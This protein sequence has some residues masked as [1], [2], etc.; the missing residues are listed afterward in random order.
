MSAP[1]LPDGRNPLMAQTL[2]IHP[3]GKLYS[4]PWIES[5]RAGA[6][7]KAPCQCDLI[8]FETPGGSR[9]E[10]RLR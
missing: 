4:C 2:A 10:G 7:P 8:S 6:D 3:N 9:L 5:P 1:R